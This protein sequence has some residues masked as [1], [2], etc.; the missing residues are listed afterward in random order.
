MSDGVKVFVGFVVFLVLALLFYVYHKH[1]NLQGKYV[2]TINGVADN[3]TIVEDGDGYV[4]DIIGRPDTYA[5]VEGSHKE[6][7][8]HL[9]DLGIEVGY[10]GAV[11]KTEDAMV[12]VAWTGIFGDY[13]LLTPSFPEPIHLDTV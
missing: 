8:K 2:A 10:T 4:L 7:Q 13:Y 1:G 12:L 11:W 5:L 9:E 3:V 6:H